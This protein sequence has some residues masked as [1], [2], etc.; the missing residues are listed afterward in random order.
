[1]KFKSQNREL[2]LEAFR[3]SLEGLP[4]TNRWVKLGDTLPWDK[5]EKIYNSRLHNV[6][7]GAGNKPARMI[8]GALLIKHKLSLS[9]VETIEA[10]R[11]NPYMQY[12]LGL[13][14][15]TDQPVFDPS[16][17]VS[18]RKRLGI[19]DYNDMSE[20]L[21]KLQV[22]MYDKKQEEEEEDNQGKGR[23]DKGGVAGDHPISRIPAQSRHPRSR[24]KA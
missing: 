15:Y 19:E 4:K 3:S 22:R 13:S 17:F 20:S 14:A 24:M 1:M 11:E 9:D 23:N 6:H 10:I 12:L 16:L 21:L 2:T 7:N 8:I 18:V 5:I